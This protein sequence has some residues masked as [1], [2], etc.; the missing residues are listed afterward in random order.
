[1][2]FPKGWGVKATHQAARHGML[3]LGLAVGAVL[4]LIT[5]T[6]LVSGA[7]PGA[8]STRLEARSQP[9]PLASA[10]SAV[11]GSAMQFVAAMQPGWNLGNSLD[12][13]PVE[14][15][16]G[17][18]PV[19]KA[20]LDAVRAQGF[21]SVR[22]PITW[23]GHEGPA[24]AYTIDPKFMSRVKQVVDWAL[25]DGFYV[26][27]NVH[28]DSWQWISG[29]PADPS[30]VLARYDATWTQI[31]DEFRD[32]P[33]KLVLESVNEPEF[34]NA[35]D[36]EATRLLNELN[37]SFHT[38]VRR[39]GGNNATRFL[40]LP[41]MRD[42][43][44]KPMIDNLAATIESLHDPRL[45]ASVHFYGFWP[46]SVNIAGYTRFDAAARQDMNTVFGLMHSQFI[47]KGIPVYMGE[48]GLLNYDYT[49][50]GIIERGEMLKYFEALGYEARINHV[51]TNLWDT[52]LFLSRSTLRPRDP[53]LWALMKASWTTRSGTAASDMIFVPKADPVTARTLTLHRNGNGFTGL[54][55]GSA[56]LVKGTDYTMSGDRLTLS[57]ALL[58][59][60]ASNRR[61]GVDATLQVR[62]SRG[63]P[64]Q[65]KVITSGLPVLADARGT[66]RSFTI[67]TQFNG[68][69]LATM[70]ARYADGSNAGPAGWTSYQEYATAFSADYTHN[71][72]LLTSAF[73]GSLTEGGR[74]TL[75]FHFWSGATVTYYVTKTGSTVTGTTS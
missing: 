9:A 31:A 47:A 65:I 69:V 30:G 51:T 40:L 61:Y 4:V 73:F 27:L 6:V 7:A 39:S 74:V 19:A 36:A 21:R 60:L 41:T 13:I 70:Q 26:V 25:S 43:P 5:L 66:A 24:P 38:L 46:F 59:R 34:G 67:P 32:E 71:D 56:K 42:A 50:P 18:P 15:S 35:G 52:G 44:A 75:T 55:D 1:M 53:G 37:T 45:I 14:T 8:Q 54:S 16:W 11:P 63:V 3:A 57:S 72:I 68:D 23:T 29:M 28:H 17:N 49:R 10:T 2:I 64:W 48:V 33:G 58:T 62:F 22:I 20:L 12:A